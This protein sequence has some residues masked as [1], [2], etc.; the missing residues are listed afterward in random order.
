MRTVI[1][2]TVII[3]LKDFNVAVII[4]A[5]LFYFFF[6]TMQKS[7]PRKHGVYIPLTAIGKMF[8]LMESGPESDKSK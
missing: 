7:A 1:T 4:G 8:L 2:P 3:P 6:K 5:S